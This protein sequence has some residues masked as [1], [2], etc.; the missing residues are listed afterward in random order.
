[1]SNAAILFQTKF[2]PNVTHRFRSAGYS[3]KNTVTPGDHLGA[4]KFRFYLQARGKATKRV[5]GKYQFQGNNQSSVDL[6][7]ET[8]EYP[9]KIKNDDL[10]RMSANFV[11]AQGKSAADGCGQV[12]NETIINAM[13]NAAVGAGDYQIPATSNLGAAAANFRITHMMQAAERLA[14][15][16]VPF[17]GNLWGIL[18]ARWWTIASMS[19]LFS[20]ADYN[21]PDLPLLKQDGL[22]TWEG[23]HWIRM[24]DEL[25][26]LVGT[27]FVSHVWHGSAVGAATIDSAELRTEMKPISDEPAYALITEFDLA[28]G[29]LQGN[30]IVRITAAAASTYPATTGTLT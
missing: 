5:G 26:P 17:D 12:A 23:V 14:A 9:V 21:G 27:D 7:A 13:A 30:G 24:P 28:A 25:C 4:D 3:L 11:D 18:P 2:A 29:V 10:R 6:A 22:R 19:E 20:S 16:G 1:M 15:V 8:Y